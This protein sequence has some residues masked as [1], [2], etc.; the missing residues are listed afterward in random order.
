MDDFK[1]KLSAI[2]A[3]KT[4]KKA[5]GIDDDALP[6]VMVKIYTKLKGKKH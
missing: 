5:K 4:G 3:R 2:R 1:Q 6:A